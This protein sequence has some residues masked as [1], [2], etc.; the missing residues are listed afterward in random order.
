MR[1][2]KVRSP[3][4]PGMY[5]IFPHEGDLDANGANALRLREVA[6]T[7]EEMAGQ[8]PFEDKSAAPP[9]LATRNGHP[10][11]V[12]VPYSYPRIE[13]MMAGLGSFAIDEVTI[14]IL[15]P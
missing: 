2:L 12:G 14:R 4:G 8:V 6:R 9:L 15:G 3:G 5:V 7:L 1:I 13:D 11:L 10:V